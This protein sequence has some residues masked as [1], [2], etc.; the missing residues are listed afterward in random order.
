[1]IRPDLF[2]LSYVQVAEPTPLGI[3]GL[4]VRETP[5]GAT[6]SLPLGVTAQLSVPISGRRTLVRVN[7][8]V[9]KGQLTEDDTRLVI[10]LGG[11]TAYSVTTS[12]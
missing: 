8:K 7:G 10:N 4:D 12:Q 3:I 11:G 5:F 2:D 1:M 6:V 9:A